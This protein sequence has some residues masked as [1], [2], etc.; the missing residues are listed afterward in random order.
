MK[1]NSVCQIDI[2]ILLAQYT[3]LTE[4]IE[5]LDVAIANITE[6]AHYKKSKGALNSFR[7]I[8]TLT[9]MTIVSE[10]GD[11]RRFAHPKQLPEDIPTNKNLES[12][13]DR[14]R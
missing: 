5:K 14:N 4:S 11:I 7:G 3:C 10:L 12:L 2:E 8:D 9:A 6:G 1:R 13:H